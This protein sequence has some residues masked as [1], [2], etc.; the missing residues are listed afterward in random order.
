MLSCKLYE[1]GFI[2]NYAYYSLCTYRKGD[3]FVVVLIYVDDS[4][5]IGNNIEACT[6]FKIYL[7]TCFRSKDLGLLKYFL[8]IEI[9]RGLQGLA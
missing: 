1:Y 4:V 9:A 6:K 2:R 7:N 8:G 3:I 5:L